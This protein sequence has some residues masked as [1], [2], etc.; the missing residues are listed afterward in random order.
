MVRYDFFQTLSII[1][2][3]LLLVTM[4]PGELSVDE[5]KKVY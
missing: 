4:G 5:K 1:G 2:G 3:L